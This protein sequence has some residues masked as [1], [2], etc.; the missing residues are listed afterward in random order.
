MRSF[1][2]LPFLALA[3]GFVAN[4]APLETRDGECDT[5]GAEICGSSFNP[6]P[7]GG[8]SPQLIN[9]APFHLTNAERLRRHQPPL[10]PKRASRRGT[11]VRKSVDSSVPQTQ[12]RGVIKVT[13]TNGEELGYISKNSFS[14]AQYRYQPNRDDALVVTFSLPTGQNSGTGLNLVTENSDITAYSYLGLVQ[15][16]DNTDSTMSTGS[17]HYG[18]LAGTTITP[19]NSSPASVDNSYNHATGK[20]R[21]A[22][23]AVWNIDVSNGAASIRWINP[24]GVAATI[25]TFSQ[26]TAL[27]FGGDRT[28]FNSKYPA[29]VT[30]ITFTFVSI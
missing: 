21:D 27:Y 24:N 29:S 8:E 2:I 17:F 20:T 12:H 26:S 10:P 22:E 3:L 7:T 23:S 1:A 5:P 16:R 15:G 6:T 9:R 4:A 14:Q 13:N 18:Y 28:Q 19:D 11:P 25:S 30:D